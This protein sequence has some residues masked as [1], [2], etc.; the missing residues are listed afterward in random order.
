MSTNTPPF[1]PPYV[2]ICQVE[3]GVN[4]IETL[5]D[6]TTRSLSAAEADWMQTGDSQ[7]V[8]APAP[9]PVTPA[10]SSD[11][12]RNRG[13]VFLKVPFAEK[14]Q[15]KALGARWDATQKKW[16]VPS[17]VDVNLFGC[18]LPDSLKE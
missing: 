1:D 5:A 13:K 14:D 4:Y 11:N 17:G 9:T 10:K 15:A 16:Y 7:S 18:W 3:T 2:S 8:N 12:T 6:G